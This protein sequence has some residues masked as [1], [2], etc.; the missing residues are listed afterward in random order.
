MRYGFGRFALATAGG[1]HKVA[2]RPRAPKWRI[3]GGCVREQRRGGGGCGE[4]P[5]ELS[6]LTRKCGREEQ[7]ADD[8]DAAE[9][10]VAGRK[11]GGPRKKSVSRSVKAG[12]QF[13]V[14]RIGRYL[15]KGQISCLEELVAVCDQPL[16]HGL[17]QCCREGEAGEPAGPQLGGQTVLR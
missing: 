16:S 9:K 11:F 5:R 17:H 4:G 3:T 7:L 6:S 2:S 1:A 8:G 13:P 14:G 12:L 15:K 10:G